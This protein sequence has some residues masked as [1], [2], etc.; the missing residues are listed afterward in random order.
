MES[1]HTIQKHYDIVIVANK[2]RNYCNACNAR[3]ALA[4][5]MSKLLFFTYKDDIGF[6]PLETPFSFNVELG[7]AVGAE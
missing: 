5:A 1:I 6:T 7:F 2:T 3:K 4:V